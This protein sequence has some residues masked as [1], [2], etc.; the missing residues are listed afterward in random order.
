MAWCNALRVKQN[1]EISLKEYLHLLSKQTKDPPCIDIYDEFLIK[2]W[3]FFSLR[4]AAEKFFDDNRHV[5]VSRRGPLPV[6][7]KILRDTWRSG[8]PPEQII[9][10][11]AKRNF[12]DIYAI[13]GNLRKVLNR[14]RQKV[15]IGTVQQLDSHCLRWLTRQP[16]RNAA[17]KG[18]S[19]QEILGV[20]RVENYNTLENR[21]LKDFLHR[22]IALATMYLRQYEK[23]YSDHVKV[24]D[25]RRFRSL[26]LAG[27]E[28]DEF[29]KVADLREMPQPNYVLQQDRLYSKVWVSYIRIMRQED[30]AEKL[31]DRRDEVSD[32]YEKCCEGIGLHCSSR[33]KYDTPLWVCDIDGKSPILESPVWEN[34]LSDTPIESP[35]PQYSEFKVGDATIIDF[36]FPWDNRDTLLYLRNHPNARPVLINKHKP[37]REPGESVGLSEI[38]LRKDA[39]Q[40]GDYIK[41]LYGLFGGARLV[42]LVPDHWESS[43]LESIIRESVSNT[44][45]PRNKVFLLWRS[46]AAVLG[47]VENKSVSNQKPIVIVD[48]FNRTRYNAVSIK[49]M[50]KNDSG[51]ILPQRASVRLHSKLHNCRGEQRFCLDVPIRDQASPFEIADLNSVRHG[52]GFLNSVNFIGHGKHITYSLRDTLMIDGVRRFIREDAEN[53]ISYFDE[54][55]AL[56]LVVQNRA[57]EVEFKVLVEHDECSPGGKV[58]HGQ[59]IKGGSLIKGSNKFSLNLLE[60]SLEDTAPLKTLNAEIDE[61]APEDQEMNFQAEMMPGQGLTTVLFSAEFLEKPMPLDMTSLKEQGY[62]KARI[63]REM[64]RHFP[65]VM[66]Y[67]EASD[68]IWASV[69]SSITTYVTRGRLPSDNGVFAKAQPYWGKVDPTGSATFRLFGDD[70]FFDEETMSPIDKLKR[71]NVFGNAPGKEVPRDDFAWEDLFERLANDFKRGRNVMRMIAWTYQANNSIFESLRKSLFNQ[72]VHLGI[73]LGPVEVSFCANCFPHGDK[74]ITGFVRRLI[75][76]AAGGVIGENE[77]RLL[78]NLTQFHPDVMEFVDSDLCE[79]AFMRIYRMYN[80]AIFFNANGHWRGA[81]ATK[82]AGYLLKCMLFILHRRRFDKEFLS[83]EEDWQ[84]Q[85]FLGQSLPTHTSTLQGHEAM[86]KSFLNYV[87]GMGTIEGIPMGD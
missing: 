33:A 81:A 75:E 28:M 48:G 61:K 12:N 80:S 29:T 44:S 20:V 85:G 65:P 66:P 19:K 72:Y 53:K 69:K 39:S 40:L 74:R 57:E 51:R 16:G 82:T 26:C 77:L 76:R 86:R 79:R 23:K 42:A 38:L 71:E 52:T 73:P 10:V 63:E 9:T 64:K 67:V 15:S 2:V 30:V 68:A 78:Y 50:K 4:V 43:W 35:D 47:L 36:S 87:R 60:G 32:L 34:E 58:Y 7:W 31:W 54:R 5:A 21:V 84:P 3:D 6:A 1:E 45:L 22:C 41:Q 59:K 25:V 24:K 14:V 13:L 62:T 8:G 49:F 46:V 11:I 55:D 27:L 37:S 70:R 17:E 18:G 83:R 56:S